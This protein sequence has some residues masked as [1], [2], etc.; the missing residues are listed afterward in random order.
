MNKTATAKTK[1]VAKKAA[2]KKVEKK[3]ESVPVKKG[4]KFTAG[5]KTYV[6]TGKTKD[7]VTIAVPAK[8]TAKKPVAKKPA[9]KKPAA[10]KED[11]V[12]VPAFILAGGFGG[13]KTPEPVKPTVSPVTSRPGTCTLADFARSERNAAM[14]HSVSRWT[15]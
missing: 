8:K 13:V 15:I 12:N 9:V 3:A 4:E 14:A 10:K 2:T 5:K 7:G 11:K 6:A 1:A